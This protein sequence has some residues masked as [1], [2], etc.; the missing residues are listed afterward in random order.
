MG[1]EQGL[2][3]EWVTDLQFDARGDLWVADAQGVLRI[4]AD[5][6][7]TATSNE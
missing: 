4:P 7:G 3:D 6:P 2:G 5:R 1:A